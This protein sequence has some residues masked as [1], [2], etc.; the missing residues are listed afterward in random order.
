MENGWGDM[1]ILQYLG[2]GL[3][4]QKDQRI[5]NNN[6]LDRGGIALDPVLAAEIK[7]L[8]E[9]SEEGYNR[10]LMA[11]YE[12][13]VPESVRK[14]AASIP[15]L[16]S[17][18]L[19]PRI[20][21]SIGHP[22]IATPRYP[23]PD[24]PKRT[25]IAAPSYIRGP[26]ELRAYCGAG[27]P[28]RKPHKG[29]TQAEL[30]AMGKIRQVR[31]LLYTWTTMLVKMATPAKTG[32]HIGDPKSAYAASSSWWQTFTSTKRMYAGHDG[33]CGTEWPSPCAGSHRKHSWLVSEIRDEARPY[34]RNLT[35]TTEA[36]VYKAAEKLGYPVLIRPT[37]KGALRAENLRE[38]D[39]AIPMLERSLCQNK[40]VPPQRPNGCGITAHREWGEVG[41]PWRP[42]HIDMAAHR[43]LHQVFLDTLW[44]VAGEDG[45]T[46]Y[47]FRWER[48]D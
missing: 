19:F 26:H 17:G 10:M 39:A 34:P 8:A 5:R 29:M 24:D 36:E 6:R 16:A 27:S 4:D 11:E 13:R 15:G 40:K 33:K 45:L 30:F 22:R 48:Q 25:L 38:L 21:A 44:E 43:N 37:D 32:K 2:Q 28:W 23:D 41:S 14:W 35:A 12:R 3:A 20:I 7:S 31:P 42:G 46:P 9:S 18:E 47:T 1:T